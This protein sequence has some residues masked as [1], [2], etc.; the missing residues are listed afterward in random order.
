MLKTTLKYA[1]LRSS[2]KDTAC[3]HLGVTLQEPEAP[4]VQ[5]QI[6]AAQIDGQITHLFQTTLGASQAYF[7][8]PQG[9]Q[10]L[11]TFDF[12]VRREL[13]IR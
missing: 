9:N 10:Y 6:L 3:E 7:L 8:D 2:D 12:F 11:L 1:Q 5:N 13:I 4:Y